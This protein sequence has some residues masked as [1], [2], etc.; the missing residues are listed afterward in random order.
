M[1]LELRALFK[2]EIKIADKQLKNGSV[3]NRGASISKADAQ[4]A[5]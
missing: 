5:H 4:L 1:S 2:N 3:G